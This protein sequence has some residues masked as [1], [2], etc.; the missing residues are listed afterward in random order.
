MFADRSNS[1]KPGAGQRAPGLKMPEVGLEPPAN[2]PVAL[3]V[4]GCLH[5]RLLGTPVEGR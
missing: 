3:R 1:K 4:N 2:R 5:L